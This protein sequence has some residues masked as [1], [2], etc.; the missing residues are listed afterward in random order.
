MSYAHRARIE[1]NQAAGVDAPTEPAGNLLSLLSVR[2][3]GGSW[4]GYEEGISDTKK[5]TRRSL[6][7][8]GREAL[9]EQ[10][11]S[12]WS[13]EGMCMIDKT[14]SSSDPWELAKPFSGPCVNFDRV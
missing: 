3:G 14:S 7:R 10:A 1:T 13:P 8:G 2:W 11:R 5:A 9:D 12:S 6:V 4:D